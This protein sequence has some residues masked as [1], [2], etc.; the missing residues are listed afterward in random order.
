[1]VESKIEDRTGNIT[2]FLIIGREQR[3]KTGRDKTSVMFA[4]SHVPGA[5][6]KVLEPVNLAGLNMVKLESRPSRH[7]NWSYYFFMDIEGHMDDPTVKTTVEKMKANSLYLKH[8]GSYP[9]F[10]R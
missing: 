8:L 4:T 7:Q 2:R 9:V 3:K 6:V 5:L 10:S 1:V